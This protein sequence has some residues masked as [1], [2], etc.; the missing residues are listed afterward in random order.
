MTLAGGCTVSVSEMLPSYQ[1]TSLNFLAGT[2]ASDPVCA[3]AE[4]TVRFSAP[5]A[6]RFTIAIYDGETLTDRVDCRNEWGRAGIGRRA[7]FIDCGFSASVAINQ[8][9]NQTIEMQYMNVAASPSSLSEAP[10][11]GTGMRLERLYRCP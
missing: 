9:D 11:S 7:T 1:A 8:I 6:Q 2:W 3:D 5:S 10:S 4:T